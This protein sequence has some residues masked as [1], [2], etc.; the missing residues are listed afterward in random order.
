M[1]N[2]YIYITFVLIFDVVDTFFSWS[3]KS[4]VGQD[5]NIA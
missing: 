3:M 2:I 4:Y 1:K 5:I